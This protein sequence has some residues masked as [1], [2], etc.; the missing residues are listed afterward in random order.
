MR[1]RWDGQTTGCAMQVPFLE[2][3]EHTREFLFARP[4]YGPV[5]VHRTGRRALAPRLA[6]VERRWDWGG[7]RD[8]LHTPRGRML[9]A[10]QTR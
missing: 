1:P 2:V 6:R 3:H 9:T 4:G 10:E 8:G 7:R 5:A